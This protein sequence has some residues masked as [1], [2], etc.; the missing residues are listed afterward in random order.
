MSIATFLQ[1]FAGNRHF[2]RYLTSYYCF[3]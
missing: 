3:G 1:F 2:Y